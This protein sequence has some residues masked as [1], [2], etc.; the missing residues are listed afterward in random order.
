MISCLCIA[1]HP[2]WKTANVILRLDQV[3]SLA[4][5]LELQFLTHFWEQIFQNKHHRFF[6]ML[7]FHIFCKG[8]CT[9]LSWILQ[10]ITKIINFWPVFW[11]V[12]F[13]HSFLRSVRKA[14]CSEVPQ[15]MLYQTFLQNWLTA[16]L[17]T[18]ESKYFPNAL[19]LQNFNRWNTQKRC[20]KTFFKRKSQSSIVGH[21]GPASR[22]L[23]ST[24]FSSCAFPPGIPGH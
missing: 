11:S 10:W 20:L 6:S 19:Y 1:Q 13:S 8:L 23:C 3:Q 12:F 2:Y 18:E 17:L 16:D 5:Y 9:I 14:L 24:K 7:L 4:I 22:N 21:S 15:E